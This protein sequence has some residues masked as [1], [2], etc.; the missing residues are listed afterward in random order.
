MS[1]YHTATH[2]KR[3]SCR[4]NEFHQW[5]HYWEH[6]C[7]TLWNWWSTGRAQR[8]VTEYGERHVLTIFSKD[9]ANADSTQNQQQ[10]IDHRHGASHERVPSEKGQQE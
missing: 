6:Y 3:R 9:H 8:N 7:N 1:Y 4:V 10:T 2:A 5:A